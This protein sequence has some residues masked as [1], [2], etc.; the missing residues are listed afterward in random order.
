MTDFKK[1]LDK[2]QRIDWGKATL[3]FYV[4]RRRLID[5]DANYKVLN[6]NID[7]RLA[8]KLRKVVVSRL[9]SSNEIHEYDYKSADLDGDFLGIQSDNTDLC[10][11]IED[12]H[13]GNNLAAARDFSD[14][15]GSWIYISRLDLSNEEPLYVV[16]KISSA[17]T[18]NKVFHLANV[19]YRDNMLV[20]LKEENVLKIDG[21]IDFYAHS[22]RIFILNKKNF[23]TALNFRQ[24]MLNNRDELIE[25]LRRYQLFKN[26]DALTDMVG[27][28][29]RL[30]RRLSQIKKAA[31]Y[32]KPEF[33]IDLRLVNDEEN[34]G[35]EYSDDGAIVITEEN[36]HLVLLLL[37]NDRLTSKINHEDFDVEVKHRINSKS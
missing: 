4:V 33:L 6:V 25:D 31:Y 27:E 16:R 13:S 24:G 36:L 18:A 26:V 2:L 14:L 7:E 19:I 5:K 30:L 21:K 12:L 9:N 22:D 29:L 8:N 1:K 20:D 35:L 11:I 17:W 3:S 23:E 32:T 10:R 28:N 34:W 15:L 37:N